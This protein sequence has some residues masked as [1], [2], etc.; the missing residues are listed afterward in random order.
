MSADQ[1]LRSWSEDWKASAAPVDLP[2]VVRAHVRRRSLLLVFWLFGEAIV[3]VGFFAFLSYRALTQEDAFERVSMSLLAAVA[4]GALAFAYVNW[5][6]AWAP[7]AETVASFLDLSFER[8]R[9]LRRGARAGWLILA[10]E[11]SVLAPWMWHRLYRGGEAMPL[12]PWSFLA[13]MVALASIS[14]V[15]LDSWA[16]REIAALESLRAEIDEN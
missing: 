8:A 15:L 3:G 5:R 7:R 14:L 9:R 4:L 12:L 10:A 6:G 2:E 13:G 11:V 1:E 16:R